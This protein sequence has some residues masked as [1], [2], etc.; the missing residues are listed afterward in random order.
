[1]NRFLP[2]IL[3]ATLLYLPLSRGA[4]PA[5][6]AQTLD[7]QLR[8]LKSE[9]LKLNRDLFILEEELLFPSNTQVSVF[10][11]FD[12]G[13]FFALD[14]VELKIDDKSVTKYLYTKAEVEALQRGGV[15]RLYLGNLKSGE[16]EIVALLTGKGPHQRDY[17]RGTT[18]KI[19]KGLGP[20][21]LELQISDNAGKQQ[22]DFIVREWE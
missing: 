3:I 7:K 15:Q 22:P 8:D 5:P 10:L 1:M 14:S 13:K 16:H 17:K 4:E 20:K 12:L 11:S 9:V 21:Y 18:L 2:L 6:P 19:D